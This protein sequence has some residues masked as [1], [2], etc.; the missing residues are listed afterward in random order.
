M[1]RQHFPISVRLPAHLHERSLALNERA[2]DPRGDFVLCWLHHAI[3]GHENPALD[4]AVHLANTLDKPV[5]VYQG[6]GGRHRFNA[7]R[8]HVFIMQGARDLQREL[9]ARGIAFAFHLPEDPGAPSPLRGLIDRSCALITEDFPAPPFPDWTRAHAERSRVAALAVD[10]ACLLPVRAL[11]SRPTRAFKFRDEAQ[12]DWDARIARV[13]RDEEPEADPFDVSSL[14]FASV[15]LLGADLDALAAS[16]DIDHSVPPV[17]YTVGGSNAG[18]ARWEAF[19]DQGLRRYASRRNDALDPEGVSRLSPYLHHGHVSPFRIAREAHEVGG[20]GAEKFLDELLTWREMAYHFCAHS[21]TQQLETLDAIPGWARETLERH[22]GDERE[23]VYTWETLSRA[24]TGDALWNG[25]QRA[26]LWSGELHNNL[27]MTWGKMIPQWTADTSEALRLLIDLNHRYA[28]DGNNPNSYGGLLW[29]LGQFDRPFKPEEPV[30]GSVRP[31]STHVHAQRLDPAAYNAV[32]R[33]RAGHGSPRV[34]VVG[35]G[36]AGLTCARTLAD[37]GC[38]VTVFDKGRGPGGRCATRFTDDDRFDH[39]CPWFEVTDARFGRCVRSWI[40]MGVAA[41][42]R[43]DFARVGDDGLRP[44]EPER[45]RIVGTPGMHALCAHLGEGLGVRYAQRVTAID[46]VGDGY[47]VRVDG[48]TDGGAFDRVVVAI[49]PTQAVELVTEP[50]RARVTEIG[51]APRWSLMITLAGE[52]APFDALAFDNGP[53]ELIVRDD[54]KPGRE[55][56]PGRRRWVAHASASWSAA[57][58]EA[59][60]DEVCEAMTALVRESLGAEEALH[61]AAHRWRYA[62]AERPIPERCLV[63]G[64]MVYCGDGCAGAGVESAFLSGQASA[65]RILAAREHIPSE[66]RSATLF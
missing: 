50:L 15:D 49:P 6:L 40:E 19:R 66:A 60:P 12:S 34:A 32:V 24:R 29:C 30:L 44:D 45:P 43:G 58:L 54:T 56:T 16:C 4:T 11:S 63:D 51:V 65:G 47:R 52:A 13:W 48:E 23:A 8:H 57:H 28:L 37:H 18:Y 21:T 10:S 42:W 33:E 53:L 35:G 17:R 2:I 27:R 31:R 20:K 26:L 41:V 25:A 36:I 46:H 62:R 9:D 22:E 5:L 38:D 55:R 7:D 61:S 59:T 64:G 14:P 1:S 39:G 3:R